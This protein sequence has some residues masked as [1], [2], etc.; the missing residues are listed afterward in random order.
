MYHPMEKRFARVPNIIYQKVLITQPTYYIHIITN[1][2][3]RIVIATV[4]TM[5]TVMKLA[6]VIRR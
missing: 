4:T 6:L 3:T 2:T 1:M 5:M